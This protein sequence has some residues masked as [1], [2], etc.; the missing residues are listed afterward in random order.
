MYDIGARVALREA[1]GPSLVPLGLQDERVVVVTADLGGSVNIGPFR[2]EFPDRYIN[3]GVAEAD[4]IGISAG[5]ASEGY[6]PFAV[7]FGSFLG[8][9]VDHIRQSIGHNR[10]KV[11]VV[12]SHGGISNAM[13]G[14]SAHA[15]E[16]IGIMR[17]MPPFAIVAP[18]CPNQLEKVLPAVAE[19]GQPVYL[20]LY[21]ERLPVF[22]REDEDFTFGKV[23]RR[24]SGND[25]TLLSY[26]PH[27]GF[28]LEWMDE[29]S[30]LGSVEL[31]EVH[32]IEPLDADGI[33]ESVRRT[34]R[35]VTVEDHFRRGGLGS[36]IGELLSLEHPAP[37]RIVALNG[38]ARSGPYYE[39]RDYVGLGVDAVGAAITDVLAA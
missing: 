9:A 29:L 33:L 11:N 21:R 6:I 28:C 35:V 26:G 10:L 18:S 32:T 8:R 31:L 27:V 1:F 22:T 12:G 37:L 30:K 17:S 16:D 15:I 2:E 20:R 36:A 39:L 4:M 23:I 19:I 34:G 13:D 25:V 3:C 38:Y 24:T 7:T 14:P 5:L